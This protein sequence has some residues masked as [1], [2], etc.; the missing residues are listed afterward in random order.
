MSSG[1]M[2][3]MSPTCWSSWIDVGGGFIST[4]AAAK[5]T[6]VTDGTTLALTRERLCLPSETFWTLKPSYLF[7]RV[8]PRT[9]VVSR[10]AVTVCDAA[11]LKEE[12]DGSN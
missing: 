1:A 10:G 8:L 6:A 4:G 2:P 12:E 3:H 9:A 7:D 5:E 11:T